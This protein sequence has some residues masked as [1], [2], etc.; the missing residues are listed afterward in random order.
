MEPEDVPDVAELLGAAFPERTWTPY[1]TRRELVDDRTVKGTFLLEFAGRPVA[2][3]SARLLPERF[4]GS[5]YLHWVAAD[6]EHRGRGHGRYVTLAVLHVFVA[7][8]CHD[9]VLETEDFRLPALRM[10]LS[11][12]FVPEFRHPSHEERWSA[13]RA[14]LDA[15]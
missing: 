13:V 2:T 1:T 5:G 15:R 10:Y 12:G 9:A 11:L 14:A 3:A 8:D 7:M 6:P 4:P